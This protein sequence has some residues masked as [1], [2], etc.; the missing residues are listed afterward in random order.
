MAIIQ[1]KMVRIAWQRAGKWEASGAMPFLVS[2]YQIAERIPA[3][4]APYGEVLRLEDGRIVIEPRPFA[5]LNR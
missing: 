3:P 2:D 5:Y 4:E 1:N